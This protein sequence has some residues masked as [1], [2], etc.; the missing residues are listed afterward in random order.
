MK[1]IARYL[2]LLVFATAII[3]ACKTSKK[4]TAQTP[5]PPIAP[6]VEKVAEAPKDVPKVYTYE[7][8]AND[9]LNARIYTLANGLKVLIISRNKTSGLV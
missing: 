9:P 5:T 8:F 1:R 2:L 7:S 6:I 4:T 3:V